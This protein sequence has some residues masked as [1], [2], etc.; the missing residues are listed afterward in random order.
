VNSRIREGK[1]R[2]RAGTQVQEPVEG[3]L[4]REDGAFLYPIRRG[5]PSMLVDDALP[6]KSA[7]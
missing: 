3:G 1:L 5:I 7:P 6:M 4:L 2:N